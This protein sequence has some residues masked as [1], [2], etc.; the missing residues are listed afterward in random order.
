MKFLLHGLT[1]RTVYLPVAIIVFFSLVFAL[2]SI[3]NHFFFRTHALDLGMFNQALYQYSIGQWAVFSQGLNGQSVNYLSD[4]FSPITI[5]L[6]PFRYLFGTYTL[7]VFQII[8]G[9]IAGSYCYKL[10]L[11]RGYSVNLSAIILLHFFSLWGLYSAFA[12]D[13]HANVFGSFLIFPFLFYALKNEK[14]KTLLFLI[15]ILI[16]K[17][18]LALIVGAIAL[19]VAFMEFRRTH[20]WN[21]ILTWCAVI[22][23]FYFLIITLVVMPSLNDGGTVSSVQSTYGKYGKNLSEVFVYFL[24]H[25][26]QVIQGIL[27]DNT[28]EVAKTKITSLFFVLLSGGFLIIIRP[29]FLIAF[30]PIIAQKFLSS[31]TLMWDIHKQYSIELCVVLS[32]LVVYSVSEL[33]WEKLKLPFLSILA[34]LA[35]YYSIRE[36]VRKSDEANIFSGRH[37]ASNIDRAEVDKIKEIIS[38]VT[39]ISVSSNLSPHLSFRSLVYTFP[40]L[41]ESEHWV[42][43]RNDFVKSFGNSKNDLEGKK[44]ETYEML[45]EGETVVLLKKK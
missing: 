38:E 8:A 7:L 40:D 37:Y 19:V 16:S 2:I 22:S 36:V 17:E 13:F 11:L 10:A 12:Y 6:S 9:A 31:N 29:I 15:L 4:H 39:V 32:L 33:K 34:S 23:V 44:D 28:G 30:I 42:L 43:T 25:P 27:L 24:S 18:N 5:L 35:L 3:P 21:K 14:W 20:R 26:L 45:F 41:G 1:K